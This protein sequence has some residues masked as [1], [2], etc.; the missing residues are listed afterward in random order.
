MKRFIILF[1]LGWQTFVYAR[2]LALHTL[3]INGHSLKVEIATD[4][5]TRE[6]GLMFREH[7]GQNEGMLFKFDEPQ[8]LCMWM[9]N[10]LIPLSVAFLD[11]NGEIINIE[12]MQPN[13]DDIHCSRKLASFALETNLN[14]F[15]KR[16]IQVGDIVRRIP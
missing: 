4:D 7:L 5:K 2:P 3:N 9:R 14:W 12:N 6:R 15:Y 16:K 8:I 1:L 11:K 10:T 13:T